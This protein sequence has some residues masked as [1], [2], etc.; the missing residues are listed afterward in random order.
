MWALKP[1]LNL[2]GFAGTFPLVNVI[3]FLMVAL[4]EG[5]SVSAYARA[6]GIKDRRVAKLKAARDRKKA[7]TGKCGGRRSYSE[8]RPD[9][10]ALAN[11]LHGKGLSY[12]KISAELAAQGHVTGRGKVHVASAIQK[13]LGRRAPAKMAEGRP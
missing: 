13:M 10:V 4:D 6:V 5:K 2:R 1:L 7:E 8:A 11:E 9:T 12:R 3:I